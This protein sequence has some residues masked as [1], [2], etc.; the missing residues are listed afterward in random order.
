M[1]EEGEQNVVSMTDT[2]ITSRYGDFIRLQ[3][4]GKSIGEIAKMYGLQYQTVCTRIRKGPPIP[5]LLLKDKICVDCE[6]PFKQFNGKQLRCGHF[7]RK[8][9]CIY[10]ATKKY[11]NRRFKT[12]YEKN[13][14]VILAE[15]NARNRYRRKNDTD[16]ALKSLLRSRLTNQ[17]R[18]KTKSTRTM[19]LLGCS[20]DFFRLH[21]E[22]LF[23]E[24]MTWENR[25]F[26]G[27]HIDHIRP[28]SSFDFTDPEQQRECF[29]YTNLQPL[30][31]HDNLVKSGNYRHGK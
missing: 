20:I 21:L 3:Q 5:R 28:C 26:Y 6:K 17:M 23:Q 9:G 22:S 18:N 11:R 19:D 27:W 24:G 8:E 1:N 30:W 4:E 7:A 2:E 14:K 13:K 12:I 15:R 25:G 31:A 16:F 10:L 29:H